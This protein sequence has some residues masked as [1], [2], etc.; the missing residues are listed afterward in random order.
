M[1]LEITRLESGEHVVLVCVGRLDADTV[2]ELGRVVAEELRRGHHA[3]RLDLEAAT[4]LSSAGIRG[5]FETQRSAKAYSAAWSTRPAI[6][7][8]GD[9]SPCCRIE[10]GSTRHRRRRLSSGW[11]ACSPWLP[12]APDRSTS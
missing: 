12:P 8:M 7:S 11:A 2:D 1:D 9:L 6:V 10:H 5:L 4:F 3:L